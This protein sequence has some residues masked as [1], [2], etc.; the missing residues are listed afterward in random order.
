MKRCSF[1]S[2]P[3]AQTAP[4]VTNDYSL[5][6]RQSDTCPFEFM[7]AMESLKDAEQLSRFTHVEARAV[8]P[9]EINVRPMI[10]STTYLNHRFL[11]RASKLKRVPQ[12]PYNTLLHST[13][14][15]IPTSPSS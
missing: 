9:S 8:I 2:P 7:L 3:P 15:A 5:D 13:L 12:E 4:A 10:L 6:D 14:P 11:P 1:F